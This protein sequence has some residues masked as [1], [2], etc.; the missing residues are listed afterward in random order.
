MNQ[1]ICSAIHDRRVLKFTYHGHPLVV[2]PYAYGL[3][4]TDKEVI[5][6]Y[7]TGGTSG[8][9]MVPLWRLIEID[10]IESLTVT[11]ER[12]EGERIGYTKGDKKM[13]AIFCEL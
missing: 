4:W 2:E 3:S 6:C 5:R 8:Y 7:Q 13:S 12:F 9:G 10:E 1:L 11:E